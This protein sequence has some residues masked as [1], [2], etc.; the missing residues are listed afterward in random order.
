MKRLLICLLLFA[1]IPVCN[2][3]VTVGVDYASIG[4]ALSSVE[5][6]EA[7]IVPEGVYDAGFI[8]DKPVSL[9]GSGSVLLANGSMITLQVDADNVVLRGFTFAPSYTGIAVYG[10]GVSLEECSFYET[11]IGVD[12]WGDNFS[13]TGCDFDACG[14]AGVRI[15]DSDSDYL[16]DNNFNNCNRGT[17]FTNS[18]ESGFLENT[19]VGCDVGVS[20]D[21]A[22]NGSFSGNVFSGCNSSF[23][24]SNS[25]GD[26][27]ED[28]TVTGG[29]FLDLENS[30]DN[31]AMSNDVEGVYLNQMYSEGNK[32]I[33]SGVNLTGDMF[34]VSVIDW[35][36]TDYVP[37]SDVLD[38]KMVPDPVR[39]GA[40]V[41]MD[42]NASLNPTTKIVPG[43]LGVYRVVDLVKVASLESH[44]D[45]IE[46]TYHL[47]NSG[48]YCCLM[49]VDSAPPEPILDAP[50]EVLIGEVFYMDATESTD[51]IGI[52][53]YNWDLG[54][55]ETSSGALTQHYYSS[56]G[57][58]VITLTV[59]D[60]AGHEA[61]A[62][63]NITV[64]EAEPVPVDNEGFKV[65]W[66]MLLAGVIIL[67]FL[68]YSYLKSREYGV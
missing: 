46:G 17:L 61:V 19:V 26:I 14:F 60:A 68:G 48:V 25:M 29:V 9:I 16:E 49:R 27:F 56:T 34:S 12:V 63:H 37:I 31:I 47:D 39:G 5:A 1:L 52:T 50:S 2:A 40:W 32:Y 66:F 8:I 64:V 53:G 58:F 11:M 54:D 41:D 7:I 51:D 28:N 15:Q 44:G 20:L 18:L 38:V 43:T 55:G 62:Y 23:I 65:T 3:E 24:V 6:G 35:A 67:G 21:G 4:D 57:D 22:V 45:L 59:S 33:F 30:V 13:L 42:I 10:S 36:F